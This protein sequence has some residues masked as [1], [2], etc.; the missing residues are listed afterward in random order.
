[1][2]AVVERRGVAAPWL[3][4]AVL[5]AF[6]A[7][8]L[9][10][11]FDRTGVTRELDRPVDRWVVDHRAAGW[12]TF[13]RAATNLG[14]PGLAFVL[15]IVL[16]GIAAVRS[17]RVALL[18][19]LVACARPLASLLVKDGVGRPRPRLSHLVAASGDS[20]PSGHVLAA[21]VVW[22]CVPLVA[23]AWGTARGVVRTLW[24]LAALLVVVV[25]CSRVY[26]GVHWLTDVIGGALLGALLLVAAYR[27]VT[28]RTI[29]G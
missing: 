9:L 2:R 1:M 4:W 12:T 16:A 24:A 26:L 5:A 11:A 22:G 28:V 29:D 10:V 19:A 20:F 3:P 23:L 18:I 7:L 27:I 25:A 13:F 14:N 8:T 6:L 15:G 21:T 17:R